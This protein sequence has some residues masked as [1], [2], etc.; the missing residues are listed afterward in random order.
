M[1]KIL[2]HIIFYTIIFQYANCYAATDSIPSCIMDMKKTFPLLSVTEYQY[3]GQPWFL[4]VKDTVAE[5]VVKNA[6]H[7]THL[8]F[9][10]QECELVCTWTKGGI[11]AL[12]RVIPDSVEKE[13]IIKLPTQPDTAAKKNSIPATD[14]LPDTIAKLAIIKGITWIE[15]TNCKEDNLYRFENKKAMKNNGV[16][17]FDGAYFNQQGNAMPKGGGCIQKY[18]WHLYNGKFSRTQF[19]PG[20]R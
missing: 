13:K 10:N 5:K 6:D 17:V 2:I 4:I 16:P 12:N 19:R 3:K 8:K 20:Y 15:E 1:K 14:I 18:W 9:Y 11:A 7:Q